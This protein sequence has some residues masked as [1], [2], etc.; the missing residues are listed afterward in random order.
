MALIAASLPEPGPFTKT[1][2]DRIPASKATPAA[3]FA[4]SYAA[5]GVFFFDPLNPDLPALDQLITSPAL[6]QSEM[7]ILLKVA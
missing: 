2:A 6:L 1:S 7:M 4:E 3:S 5:Y